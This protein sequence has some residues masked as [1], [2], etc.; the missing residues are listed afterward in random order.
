MGRVTIFT[1]SGCPHCV[2]AKSALKRH[3]L[4]FTEIDVEK[5]PERRSDMLQLTDKFSVPQIFFNE[6]LVGGADDLMAQLGAWYDDHCLVEQLEQVL[7]GDPPMDHRLA[8]TKETAATHALA[9][10]FLPPTITLPDGSQSSVMQVTQVLDHL[11]DSDDR[12]YNAHTYKNCFV[13][14]EAVKILKE[15]YNLSS[16]KAAV[17]WGKKLQEANIL[18]HVCGD[19]TFREDGYYFFRLQKYHQPDVLNSLCVWPHQES[20]PGLDYSEYAQALL[21]RLKSKLDFVL[22]RFTNDEG[23]INYVA[24]LEDPDF[25]EFEFAACEL[26]G[27]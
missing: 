21:K 27:M 15:N 24:V 16:T 13:N 23:L 17:D 10:E 20:I 18:H 19:H 1:T 2:R 11:L 3:D 6:R 5:N 25:A 12:A 9:P 4:A 26:Q 8:P 7:K 14:T 22:S